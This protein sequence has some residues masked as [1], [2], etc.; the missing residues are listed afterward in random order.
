MRVTEIRF[1]VAKQTVTKKRPFIM[2]ITS[3]IVGLLEVNVPNTGELVR[4]DF[5]LETVLIELVST[6]LDLCF[7]KHL[8]NI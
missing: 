8:L 4:D 2:K 1:D 5:V 3:Q 6:T 7:K